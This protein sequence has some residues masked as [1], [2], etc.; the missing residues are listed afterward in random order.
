MECK[1]RVSLNYANTFNKY[2]EVLANDGICLDLCPLQSFKLQPQFHNADPQNQPA[3]P[4]ALP[5][6]LSRF[7]L[8]SCYDYLSA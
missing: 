5:N 3:R 6:R 1:C 8:S 4:V 7:V 2:F